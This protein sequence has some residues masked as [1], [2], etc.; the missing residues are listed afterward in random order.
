MKSVLQLHFENFLYT[1]LIMRLKSTIACRFHQIL[2]LT[3][4]VTDQPPNNLMNATAPGTNVY[5]IVELEIINRKRPATKI[6]WL[7]KFMSLR[8]GEIKERL[9][10]MVGNGRQAWT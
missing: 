2:D 10:I 6:F 7:L 3:Y 1:C 5:L 4:P 8:W 9:L